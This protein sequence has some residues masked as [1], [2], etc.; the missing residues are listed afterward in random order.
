MATQSR[1]VVVSLVAAVLLGCVSTNHPV[2]MKQSR[3]I[4]GT[5]NDVRVDAEIFGDE[6][7]PAISIPINYDITNQ[8]SATIAIADMIPDTSY[9]PET[10][11]VTVSIGSEV[12]GENLVPRLL[13]IAP[14]EKK[15]FSTVARFNIMAA[16]S[17]STPHK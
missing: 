16:R 15:S 2:D 7:T 17:A 1:S 14:G 10:R 8:R 6:L 12:P 3:R 13:S 4:V 9:D 5:E 11:I